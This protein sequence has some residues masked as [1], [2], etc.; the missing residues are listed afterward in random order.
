MCLKTSGEFTCVIEPAHDQTATINIPVEQL[1]EERL[2]AAIAEAV[3]QCLARDMGEA[4]KST[5]NP[6]A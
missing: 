3:E 6:S 5:L 2:K 1:S 4:T